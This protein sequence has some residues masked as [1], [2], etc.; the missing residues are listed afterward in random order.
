MQSISTRIQHA[1]NAHS[2]LRVT[3]VIPCRNEVAFIERC[4]ASVFAF[5]EIPGGYEVLVVDGMST[6]G[7]REI[8]ARLSGEHPAL[9]VLDNPAHIVPTAM[10][11]GI[12]AAR[13]EL[14]V[15]LDAHSE[16]PPDYL[17]RSVATSDQTGAELVGGVVVTLARDDSAQ[18]RLVQAI[19]THGFGVGNSDFRLG[20]KPGPSDTVPYGCY[21]RDVFDRIGYFDER[22]RRSEDY[23]LNRRLATAGGRIWLDPSMRIQYYNQATLRGLLRQATFTGTWNPWRWY[24]APYCFTPRHTIPAIFVLILAI[25]AILSP[26]SIVARGGLAAILGIYIPLA[27]FSGCQQARRYGWWMAP[28]LPFLFLVYHICYGAGILNGV[29]RILLHIAPIQKKAEPWPGADRFRAWPPPKQQRRPGLDFEPPS[30]RL[31]LS[32]RLYR[33]VG[34]R[35][36]DI[37]V[38]LVGLVFLSP[39]FALI[40]A[41]IV[42]T[43]GF[44]VLYRQERIGRHARMF[45][46]AK[47]R[48]M[49]VG[50]DRSGTVTID[51]DSR[52][53]RFGRLLRRWKLD[54]LPQLWNVLRGQMSL[55]GP[56]PDV[57]GLVDKLE[58]DDRRILNVRPGITGLA[59]LAFRNEEAIL[60]GTDDPKRYHDEVMFPE[61][62]RLNL[63]YVDHYGFLLDL[64]CVVAT[65]L[66]CSR[67]P[68][69]VLTQS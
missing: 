9:R 38:A 14:I 18:A 1:D 33:A 27:I 19:S 51:G 61:K 67:R 8:L 47:F 13:G 16:Y 5:P 66:S 55:V 40:A 52:I 17:D 20:A 30:R 35:A 23:E 56:R 53:T 46:I 7:T 6:D 31:V 57:R 58:G 39:A 12:R 41:A 22:L 42:V 11:I 25:T 45:R 4:L 21:R 63:H 44:P 34:K 68:N 48:T 62:L 24:I 28:I 59:T 3:I 50:A 29:V 60:A 37:I 54:E 64:R 49:R 32:V 36:F 65:I 43:D 69:A 15:R 10:N 2:S 26:I